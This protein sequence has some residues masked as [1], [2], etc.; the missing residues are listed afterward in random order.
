MYIHTCIPMYLPT[1]IHT[2][3]HMYLPTY[4]HTYIHLYMQN[5][6]QAYMQT[7]MQSCM[8]ACT[9]YTRTCIH[10]LTSLKNELRRAVWGE[11]VYAIRFWLVRAG[12]CVVRALTSLKNE[13]RR[14]AWGEG[15]VRYPVLAGKGWFLLVRAGKGWQGLVR[16]RPVRGGQRGAE[17]GICLR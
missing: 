17:L 4:I 16:A 9:Q 8:Y 7:C 15:S 2:Y 10:K 5:Y 6:M 11:G 1:Y 3:I 12:L 14:A 13:L